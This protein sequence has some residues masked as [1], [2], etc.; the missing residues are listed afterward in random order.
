MKDNISESSLSSE[1]DSNY[2]EPSESDISSESE[3]SSMSSDEVSNKRKLK[4]NLRNK[5]PKKIRKENKTTEFQLLPSIVIDFDK[6]CEFY[7]KNILSED[8]DS[9]CESEDDDDNSEDDDNNEDGEDSEEDNKPP[10]NKSIE[11]NKQFGGATDSA[12]T[13]SFFQILTKQFE[14]ENS[15]IDEE[16]EPFSSTLTTKHI[17]HIKNNIKDNYPELYELS[18][19]CS[20]VNSIKNLLNHPNIKNEKKIQ[21]I[22]KIINS[23]KEDR[24]V[25]NNVINTILDIPVGININ[26]SINVKETDFLLRAKNI[27][28]DK[29]IGMNN[30]KEEILDFL[31]KL[32]MN[33]FKGT[34]LGLEGPPGIGKCLAKDTLVLMYSGKVKPVQDITVN[35]MLMGPDS[36]ARLVRSI[37]SGKEMM[38]TIK[39]VETGESYTVNESHILSLKNKLTNEI[40]NI[41]VL[42]YL[43]LDNHTK[44]HLYG[45]RRL[46]KFQ[47]ESNIKPSLN[48]LVENIHDEIG[49]PFVL[50]INSIGNRAKVLS[51]IIY[52]TGYFSKEYADMYIYHKN[53]SFLED[54]KF[55]ARSLGIKARLT[56]ERT[57]NGKIR[58]HLHSWHWFL[59]IQDLNERFP[60]YSSDFINQPVADQVYRI[61]IIKNEVNDYY[62][63]EITGDRLFVL[64]DFSVTHNTRLCR[65]LGEILQLPFNQ[66]SM[67]G[68]NDSHVLV[69]H[70]STYIGA[71]PGKLVNMLISSKCMNPI[72]Y[73]DECFPYDQ[74]IETENGL[75]EIGRLYKMFTDKQIIN[76]KSY[77]IDAN[78]F[79]Y[80]PIF[81]ASIREK[82]TLIE[83]KFVS[84]NLDKY[85]FETKCS[86]NHPFLTFY[87]YKYA[88]DLTKNDIVLSDNGNFE[89][90]SKTTIYEKTT[91]Y[92][93]TVPDN[94][95]FIIKNDLDAPGLIVHNCDKIAE[96][97]FAE[98]N[99]VLTHLLDEE[100]NGEFHDQYL[101]DFTLDLSKVLFVLSY[102]DPSTLNPIVKNRIKTIKV[103]PPTFSEKCEIIKKIFIPEYKNQLYIKKYDIFISDDNIRYLSTLTAEDTGMRSI[104]KLIETILNKVNTKVVLQ[105]TGSSMEDAKFSYSN[106]T[107]IFKDENTIEITK[108]LISFIRDQSKSKDKQEWLNFYV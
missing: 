89:L 9:G 58:L 3:S 43:K 12:Y 15:N 98:I 24:N 73:L 75:I 41:N 31:C 44:S 37:T 91:L 102:N 72:I 32:S 77:N 71:K 52:E 39:D 83:L 6:V 106:I 46:I 70:S 94:N 27:L 65:A 25:I 103:E 107:N 76:V 101:D 10:S 28:D 61:E 38:Y 19:K 84:K 105:E 78:K 66:L 97:K 20:I 36:N 95:N 81:D 57:N 55:L 30:V 68:M 7:E 4:Y 80:K 49:L 82:T 67:G 18:K 22:N 51:K 74:Q 108:E 34:V 86:E 48:I 14:S 64:G 2:N 40:L 50:K 5:N 104:K 88:K 53:L 47:E 23:S 16:N 54:C 62:G 56:N 13:N 60:S 21:L 96:S 17:T 59:Y 63:F 1:E 92:D 69:G 99:G 79:E 29:I 8:E 100:Q 45:Y 93:L 35:D 11:I 85:V 87:G 33:S 90:T 42:D 26:N